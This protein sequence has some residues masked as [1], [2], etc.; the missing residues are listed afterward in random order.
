[1]FIEREF[2]IGLR[3]ITYN[4]YL[5]NT[6]LLSYLENMGGIHS[7]IAKFGLNEI[8]DTE[9]SW[10]LINWKVDLYKRLKYDSVVKVKTWS[11]LMDGLYAYRD[12]QIF[13]KDN[14][15][16][17]I[18]TS[19]WIIVNIYTKKIMKIDGEIMENYEPENQEVYP[20]LK[21]FGKLKEAE[22]YDNKIDFHITR[23][24]IDINY[25]VHNIYYLD[26]AKEVIPIDVLK[27]YNLNSFEVLY[28]KEIKY[29]DNLNVKVLYKELDDSYVV[30]IKSEDESVLHAIIKYY[31]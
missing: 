8:K 12:F 15:L 9:V 10:V 11:R 23:N 7:S 4:N 22:D 28:K 5:S 26:M 16:I 1:M 20:G 31:K 27:E 19:K 13:D 30:T 29:E 25:H 6:S 2:Y 17:G 24:M 3:D 21:V 14:N 18:A